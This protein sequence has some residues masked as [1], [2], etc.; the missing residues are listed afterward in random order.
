MGYHLGNSGAKVNHLFV[1]DDLKLYK[2]N[3]KEIGS[4]VKTF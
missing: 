1:M 3:Y 2:K 4:F